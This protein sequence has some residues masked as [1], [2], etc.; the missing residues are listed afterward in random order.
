MGNYQYIFHK[1]D[2]I[3]AQLARKIYISSNLENIR[4]ESETEYQSQKRFLKNNYNY[5]KTSDSSE[6]IKYSDRCMQSEAFTAFLIRE[7]M[8]TYYDQRK[9]L[10]NGNSPLVKY[11]VSPFVIEH[12]K[13]EII[14]LKQNNYLKIQNIN[15]VRDTLA[16]TKF[17]KN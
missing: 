14:D 8:D 11:L 15:V 13:Q 6:I 10:E 12:N 16:T 5:I 9:E 1:R 17:N 4:K 2:I 7:D 3:E